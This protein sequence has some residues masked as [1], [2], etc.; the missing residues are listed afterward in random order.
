MR[1]GTLRH[2]IAVQSPTNVASETS[3]RGSKTYATDST[4]RAS[5]RPASDA[6]RAFGGKLENEVTHVITMRWRSDLT[7][8]GKKR[9]KFGT[10]VFHVVG[11][12][13]LDERD[14]ELIIKVK[15]V[16]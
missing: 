12:R 8:T 16:A 11:V 13:N 14:R 9:L 3:D 1:A 10:R 5:I 15:E 4:E 2:R 6:E 7:V